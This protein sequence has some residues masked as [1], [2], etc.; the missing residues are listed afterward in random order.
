M[1]TKIV[2]FLAIGKRRSEER[3][4][5]RSQ[6]PVMKKRFLSK[7][8]SRPAHHPGCG[9]CDP[10]DTPRPVWDIST[11]FFKAPASKQL[12]TTRDVGVTLKT[13]DCRTVAFF[14]ENGPC[15]SK[16]GVFLELS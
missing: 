1:S 11:N 4:F 15:N 16:T 6:T 7:G 8:S 5:S 10:V 9:D 12:A 13:V 3:A 14:P 2:V